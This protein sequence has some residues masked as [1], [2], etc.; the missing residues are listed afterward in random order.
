MRYYDRLEYSHR[1]INLK[2][3]SNCR[4]DLVWYIVGSCHTK[5]QL[6]LVEECLANEDREERLRQKK[7]EGAK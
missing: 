1:F 6:L 2:E 5:E 7:M 3:K 4:A